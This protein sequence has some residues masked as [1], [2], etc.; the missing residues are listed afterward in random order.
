MTGDVLAQQLIFGIQLGSLYAVIALGYTMVYGVLRLINF[1]HG[2][3]YMIGSYIAFY[4]CTS[5]LPFRSLDSDPTAG[6]HNVALAFVALAIAML[7]CATLGVMIER[8]AYRPLR[9]GLTPADA[10]FWGAMAALPVLVRL[11]PQAPAIRYGSYAVAAVAAGYALRPLMRLLARRV[12]PAQS[13]LAALITAI[14]VSLA[15][16]NGGFLVFGAN[17]NFVPN[18]IPETNFRLG[19]GVQVNSSQI[20]VVVVCLILMAVL[21]FIVMKTKPGKAMRAISHDIDAAKL[22]GIDTDRTIAFT[23]A[24]GGAM[25]G[26]AGAMVAALTHVKITPLFGLLPGIK[27]FVAAVLGGAGSIPGAALGGT[28]MGVAEAFVAGSSAS[29][30][31]DA[32]AFFILIA[33]LLVRPA[34]IMGRSTPEKV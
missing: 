25:A 8:F 28:I 12:K 3:V 17:P 1:A 24:L 20:I 13:R 22:M 32:I 11:A 18:I 30:F 6:P 27:A 33:I 21:R 26:A 15:L 19:G 16:E 29:T 5:W 31:R 2:D 9:N 14:G 10:H 23:F 34:G 4:A 7:I